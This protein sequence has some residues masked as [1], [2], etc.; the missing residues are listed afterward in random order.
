MPLKLTTRKTK[1][2]AT[3]GPSSVPKI[4][5][6]IQSGVNV[7]R[8]NFSHIYDPETQTPIIQTIRQV[9]AELCKPVAI[10]GD[11]GGPK[12][13]CN[14]FQPAVTE[15]LLVSG[16]TVV[17]DASN[18]PCSEGRITTT[19]ASL[20]LS[21]Q[22]DHRVLIDDGAMQL[23]MTRRLSPSSIEL[24]VVVG[25]HLKPHKGINVPDIRLDVP[26]L[27]EKDKLDA[28]Y[29]W[30]HRLDYVALS[31][32]QVASD[33]Q[34][35]LDLFEIL[36]L[37]PRLDGVDT[38]S[39]TN[40]SSGSLETGVEPEYGE[41]FPQ[42]PW[43]P[44]IISKIEKPQAL[45]V[46]DEIIAVTDGIMVARGDLGVEISLERVPIIQKMLIRKANA[47]E[48]PVITATQMLESMIHSPFPTR[49]EVSDVANAVLDGTDAV[50]LSGECAVGDYPVETVQMM[51]NICQNAESGD[52]FMQQPAMKHWEST[53]TIQQL[54]LGHP[55]ANAAVSASDEARAVALIVFTYTGDMAHFVSKRRPI[56]PIIAVTHKEFMYRRLAL[57]YGVF[58]VLST[59][60]LNNSSTPSLS[61]T[62][63]QLYHYTEQ[64]IT[65]H[66]LMETLGL[67][68]GSVVT[69]CAGFHGPWPALSYTVKLSLFKSSISI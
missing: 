61:M 57:L 41:E 43:R 47:A 18:D 4:R 28:V 68:S 23:K 40:I 13:R 6:L 46:I 52:D 38:S 60:L 48:K 16:S 20:V 26:A 34:Q 27:T 64:D 67:L 35:L 45:D 39:I 11:L 31:F 2:V 58:P 66:G 29:M 63:D 49:A 10:L 5:E 19:V 32:V 65:N 36:R 54:T 53:K 15:I 24:L 3:L 9:S 22:P 69:Y 14:A 21:L 25:G 33:V 42:L 30:D 44:L 62:A 17:L 50:M 8:L 55:I 51:S 59:A 37:R 1:I 56:R 7:F 12:I